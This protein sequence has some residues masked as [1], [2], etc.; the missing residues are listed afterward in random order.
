MKNRLNGS[1]QISGPQCSE[2]SITDR[3][4]DFRQ[5][6]NLSLILRHQSD[7]PNVETHEAFD[8]ITSTLTHWLRETYRTS[9]TEHAR[10][11]LSS[12]LD[13]TYKISTTRFT[14][15]EV[16]LP[17][18]RNDEVNLLITSFQK[19]LH[20]HADGKPLVVADAD[21]L[22]AGIQISS[23]YR[24]LRQFDSS[25]ELCITDLGDES[26]IPVWLRF[27]SDQESEDSPMPY[28]SNN[29]QGLVALLQKV[30]PRIEELIEKT[31]ALLNRVATPPKIQPVPDLSL[32]TSVQQDVFDAITAIKGTGAAE[33]RKVQTI[34]NK[35]KGQRVTEALGRKL[36]QT[37]RA[38]RWGVRCSCGEIA[39]FMWQKNQ[40]CL[41]GGL[42]VLSHTNDGKQR[43][44]NST[45]TFPG[46]IL[47]ERPDRR[48]R[49]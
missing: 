13:I 9:F 26:S 5:N 2:I 20:E 28:P 8:V 1:G 35:L 38:R 6:G 24:Q 16:L 44:H 31:D 42:L 21:T 43:F 4:C 18:F 33:R 48:T 36:S 25:G 45:T 32:L 49:S 39:Q 15:F 37:L 11:L 47:V 40:R 17:P 29:I 10:V 23:S 19:L 12:Y 34:L 3:F 7:Q 27:S 14:T 41:E 30:G 22:P 46:C